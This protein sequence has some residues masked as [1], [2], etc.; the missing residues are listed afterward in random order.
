MFATKTSRHPSL[1]SQEHIARP[2]PQPPK[3][4]AG[5]ANLLW[6][7]LAT[8]PTALD[9][10]ARPENRLHME[11]EADG[12]ADKLARGHRVTSQS[13]T[14]HDARGEPECP[15]GEH[16][17]AKELGAGEKLPQAQRTYF[18]ARMGHDLSAIRLHTDA[19]AARVA[20]ALGLQAF[21]LGQDIVF[22]PGRYAPHT[23][24]GHW[25]LAHELA[26]AMQT[27]QN[28]KSQML[29]GYEGP[30][31]RYFGDRGAR[32]LLAFLRT[33]DGAA[34]AMQ[35]G[36]ASDH[37]IQ[38]LEA[39]P[40]VGKAARIRVREGLE[41][42][43]GEIIALAGDFY[44]G[45]QSL[46]SADPKE[47]TQLLNIM[48]EQEAGRRSGEQANIRFERIT[49]GRYSRLAR[50]NAW[51][52]QKLHQDA[53]RLARTKRTPAGLNEAYLIDAAGNHFLTDA[54]ASGHLIDI[55]HVERHIGI[56]LRTNA[57]DTSRNPEMAAIVQGLKASGDA[58]KL[59]LKNLHDRLN[60][61]GFPI[62]NK[63][64]RA[65]RTYG[66]DRLHL[67]PETKR[68]V[69]LAVFLSR[70]QV[71]AAHKGATPVAQE[72]LD[73]LPDRHSIDRATAYAVQHIPAAAREVMGLIYRNAGRLRTIEAPPIPVIGP[74][75][76]YAAESLISTISN[77]G[78]FV[79]QIGS[80][81]DLDVM[82]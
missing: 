1:N 9:R 63:R 10:R 8:Q 12:A 37:L 15:A 36:L 54:F 21:A 27:G 68:I 70:Q 25:L 31:H 38:Q 46:Q 17:V 74:L 22:A 71:T 47:V 5:R 73:M 58:V 62:K 16:P 48:D 64:G 77:P 51:K 61:E 65:W 57:I 69:S 41:L 59:V 34:W 39:D 7:K 28:P 23:D 11:K 24:E 75:L 72:I 14:S 35:Q 2:K 20:D 52:W 78:G 40:F 45:P 13:L 4:T 42:T 19:R 66:D 81:L 29:L 32:E 55:Q 53:I 18:E 6:Q 44:H 26:H 79:A 30:E 50:Q 3:S 43:P 76:P 82:I 80:V 49:L 56:Y 60:R 67:A 33:S